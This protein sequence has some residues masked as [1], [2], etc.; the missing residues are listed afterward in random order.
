MKT[1]LN[2]WKGYVKEMSQRG[3][4]YEEE[5]ISILNSVGMAGNIKSGAGASAAA[6]DADI[7]INGEIY[8]IEVKLNN[9]AQMGGTSIRYYP[10]AD[11]VNQKF[12]IV[13]TAVDEDTVELIEQA[14]GDKVDDLNNLLSFLG[15]KHF[16][17]KVEVDRWL[18][19]RQ[20]GLLRPLNVKIKRTSKFIVD[21]YSK[22]G[23]DYIQIGGSGLFYLKNNPAN[24]PIPQLEGEINVEIRPG[25]SGSKTR[26]D[27]VKIAAAGIRVQARLQFDGKS[28]YSLDNPEQIRQMIIQAA[29]QTIE[30]A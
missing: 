2:N 11:D 1:I 10:M 16:P 29:N 6:A 12:S 17:L 25:R 4:D 24:L 21:H 20:A 18:E 26:K 19:A 13:S 8:K 9:K 22:K 5:I 15:A 14:L 28:P 3:F 27:G 30:P 7:N 23:I